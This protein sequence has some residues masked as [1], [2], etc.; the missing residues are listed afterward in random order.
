MPVNTNNINPGREIITW[1]VHEYDKHDR[2]SGW[3]FSAIAITLLLLFLASF[4]IDL[5]PFSI[6]FVPNFLFTI[7]VVLG[8][9]IL[10]THDG[11][12]PPLVKVSLTDEGIVVGRK[13]YDYDEIKDFSVIYKP[14]Q[15]VKNLYLEFQNSL[16]PRMSISLQDVNPLQIREN[17]LKYISEDLDRT[18]QP[19]SET[20]AKMLK[21]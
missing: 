13:F 19:L 4:N 17:L 12:E 10:I 3:Y 15:K 14:S 21:L 1:N 9:I 16:K 2:S 7:I 5:S 18:D 6:T 11:Q 8:A 20:L